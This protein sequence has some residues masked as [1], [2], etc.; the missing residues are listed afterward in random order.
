MYSETLYITK[1]YGLDVIADALYYNKSPLILQGNIY[2]NSSDIN[3]D[4]CQLS[5]LRSSNYANDA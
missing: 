4:L 1:G 2:G 5:I 3:L